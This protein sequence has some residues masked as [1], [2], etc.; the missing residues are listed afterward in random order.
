M[1]RRLLTLI[2]M[3]CLLLTQSAAM[4]F[5]CSEGEQSGQLRRPH[6]HTN[7]LFVWHDHHHHLNCCHH[8]NDDFDDEEPTSNAP[9]HDDDAVYVTA[10]TLA[11]PRSSAEILTIDV[12]SALIP[13][14]I[15]CSSQLDLQ[16]ATRWWPPPLDQS[17]C[18]PIYLQ[19]LSLLI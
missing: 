8:H 18:C 10:E 1:V 7:C 2:L 15:V 12:S 9:D 19:H 4:G 16:R 14:D 13:T 17:C 3:P 11:A 5:C 6:I